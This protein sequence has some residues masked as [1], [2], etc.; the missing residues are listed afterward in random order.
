[1]YEYIHFYI[2]K[3]GF[4]TLFGIAQAQS[5]YGRVLLHSSVGTRQFIYSAV[6]N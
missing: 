3:G 5:P 4:V 2:D 1:M 6:L